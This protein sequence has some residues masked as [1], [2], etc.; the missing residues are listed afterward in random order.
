MVEAQN[1][2]TPN[3]HCLALSLLP[4]TGHSINLIANSC[5]AKLARDKWAFCCVCVYVCVNPWWTLGSCTIPAPYGQGG[6]LSSA[7]SRTLK[8]ENCSQTC[9]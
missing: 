3:L 2:V 8:T 1:R 4:P 5:W 7:I 6:Y 9:D